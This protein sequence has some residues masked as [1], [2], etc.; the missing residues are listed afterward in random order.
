MAEDGP[1]VTAL[2]ASCPPLDPN[3]AY[4]NLLQ[5]SHFSD[6]C[7]VAE[8]D[9]KVV[10]W[11]SGYRL[12]QDASRFF[13][14]QVAVSS[15]Q[16]GRGLAGKMLD[17]LLE[18]DEATGVTHVLTTVTRDND[19]SRA[20]FRNWANRHDAPLN[21]SELF[22]RDRHFAGKHDSEWQIAI[23]PLTP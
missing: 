22:D 20:M 21:E 13:V 14:W 2:I 17:G 19:A 3:S 5:C 18:R 7:I 6:T 16:R 15:S 8:C 12:P 11:I 9:G 10:G 1:A 23:G 4:C